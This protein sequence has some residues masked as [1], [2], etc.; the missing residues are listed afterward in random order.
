MLIAAL[1]LVSAGVVG[2]VRVSGGTWYVRSAPVPA[3]WPEPTPVGEVQVKTYPVYR[4]AVVADADVGGDGMRPMFMALFRH[5]QANEISMTA[6]VEMGY[7]DGTSGASRME[8]M[9]F[10]YR[11]R[12]LGGV[13]DEGAV[14]VLDVEPRTYASVG[15][16]GDYTDRN[17]EKGLAVLQA[18]L[19]DNAGRVSTTGPPRYLGYNGPFVPRFMRY[20]EVQIPIA[21][22]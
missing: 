3:D 20:G 10:L 13:G 16:R 9:A 12:D 11:T 19:A 15:V 4:A 21:E 6:P 17:F 2:C 18:W 8:S 5:I 7:G 22:G 14:R 1:L